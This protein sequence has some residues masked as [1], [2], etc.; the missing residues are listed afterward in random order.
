MGNFNFTTIA[1]YLM[2]TIGVLTLLMYIFVLARISSK[3]WGDWY[4]EA[5]ILQSI[6]GILSACFYI[7]Y[8]IFLW[9]FKHNDILAFIAIL[10]GVVCLL[11]GLFFTIRAIGLRMEAK[12]NAKYSNKGK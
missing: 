2:L 7:G 1:P 8:A 10:T 11:I 3:L 12:E 6:G 9:T 4:H 5:L